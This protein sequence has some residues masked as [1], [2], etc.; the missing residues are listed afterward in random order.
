[1]V[2]RVGTAQESRLDQAA[3]ADPLVSPARRLDALARTRTFRQVLD[4]DTAFLVTTMLSRV[5]TAG[6]AQ[7]A[8][9]LARPV[10]G[11]TGTTNENTDAW[12]VGATARLTAVVWLG[13]D[14]PQVRLGPGED[15]AHAALPLWI[16]L[17]RAAEGS[18][19]P[20]A[21]PGPPTAGVTAVSVNPETGHL[22]EAGSAGSL[23][24]FLRRGTEP[25]PQE[26]DDSNALPRDLGSVT[27]DF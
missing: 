15:G 23:S 8:Q 27:T 1:M 16:A 4:P 6:T 10:I 24:V 20:V 14:D 17:V 18:R 22:T 3:A 13:H 2:K 12:F 26:T 9:T 19:P 25:V 11:K 5:V 21:L 7:G